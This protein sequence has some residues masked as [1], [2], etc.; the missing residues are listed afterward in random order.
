MEKIEYFAKV[1]SIYCKIYLTKATLWRIA[2]EF[3]L[4]LF[5]VIFSQHCLSG[6]LSLNVFFSILDIKLKSGGALCNV[7]TST[8]W[9]AF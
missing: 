3:I 9:K 1:S 4:G 5:R 8:G 6:K 2:E 7:K